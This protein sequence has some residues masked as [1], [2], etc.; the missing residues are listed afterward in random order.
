MKL[1]VVIDCSD[2]HEGLCSC[3]AL[4]VSALLTD[5]AKCE[6]SVPLDSVKCE[7]FVD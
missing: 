6:Y 2:G 1:Y 3:T 7:S 4:S 5:N